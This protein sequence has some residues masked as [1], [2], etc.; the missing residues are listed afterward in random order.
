MKDFLEYVAKNIV[1]NMDA[2]K[3]VQSAAEDGTVV[4]ELSVDS[5][6]M[7]KIIGKEGRIIKA[8]RELVRILAIKQGVRVNVTV[9]EPE[10]G[11][12][13]PEAA[14]EATPADKP[15]EEKPQ[16]PKTRTKKEE[17]PKEESTE[18]TPPAE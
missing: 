1:D 5:S 11:K 16:T 8:I 2:V 13:Q 14:P 12:V 4:L 15:Q 6:D 7:G 9:K 10:G 3:V 17:P 18:P